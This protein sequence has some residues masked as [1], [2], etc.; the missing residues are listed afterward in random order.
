MIGIEGL[1]KAAIDPLWSIVR[2]PRRMDRLYRSTGL[3]LTCLIILALGH[4]S[5]EISVEGGPRIMTYEALSKV[6]V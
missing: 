6:K 2:L 5:M 1:N 3:V 4:I